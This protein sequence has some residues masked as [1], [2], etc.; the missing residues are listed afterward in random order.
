MVPTRQ[1]AIAGRGAYAGGGV[2]IGET[3]ALLGQ[4][5]DIRGR[6]FAFGIIG[7][8]IAITLVIRQDNQDIRSVSRPKL[9]WQSDKQDKQSILQGKAFNKKGGE[10]ACLAILFAPWL[11]TNGFFTLDPIVSPMPASLA[12]VAV[13]HP[14]WWMPDPVS[15]RDPLRDRRATVDRGG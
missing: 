10:G 15:P 14:A 2:G 5:I 9:D 12:K 4:A 13:R 1:Q 7:R 11:A 6:D 8:D 3:N